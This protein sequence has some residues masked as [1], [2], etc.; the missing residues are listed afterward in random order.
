MIDPLSLCLGMALGSVSL[1]LA[2]IMYAMLPYML[3]PK[4]KYLNGQKK[5]VIVSGATDGIG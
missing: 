4:A 1:K 5:L 2:R 3:K